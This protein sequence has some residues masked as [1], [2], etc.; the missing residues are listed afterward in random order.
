M[1]CGYC[2]L[3]KAY[4]KLHGNYYALKS[5]YSYHGMIDLTGC[6]TK[7]VK[8]PATKDNF[9]D[10]EEEAYEIFESMLE[11]DEKGYLITASTPGKDNLT[12]GDGKK[13]KAGLV[14]GHAYSVIQVKEYDD[15]QLLNIRNPWGR[16]EWDGDWSDTSPLWTEE[17]KEA[18]NPVLDT[19]DGSFW[20]CLKDFFTKFKSITYWNVY[21][22]EELRL[23]GK[24]IKVHD[25]EDS[26][27]DYVISKFYYSFDV[28][29]DDTEI[30]IGIHQEDKR[31]VGSHLRAYLDVTFIILK[32]DDDDEDI[33]DFYDIADA[34]IDR[35]NFKTFIF[36]QGSYVVIP[37]TTG[38]L[39]Q[40]IETS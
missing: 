1:N 28:D 21:N 3:K 6:P 37:F 39:L 20:M 8:F 18:F 35:E 26:T 23:R 38:G 7:H 24:F 14:P 16:F 29:E 32:R 15:I 36:D 5:G 31:W 13:P 25:K 12:T 19:E 17:M 10:V 2:F 4:A 9:D 22:W 40:W 33:L 30:T 34:S 27:Q 11:A